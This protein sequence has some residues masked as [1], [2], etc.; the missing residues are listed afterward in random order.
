MLRKELVQVLR[1]DE[2]Q[3]GVS[4]ELQPLVGAQGEVRVADAAV[5]EGPGQQPYVVEL[6]ADR[7][8]ELGQF[9]QQLELRYPLAVAGRLLGLQG[10]RR[11]IH[12]DLEKI[13]SVFEKSFAEHTIDDL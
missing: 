5:R 6:D 4:E 13:G 3:N 1:R 9:L 7:L 10:M 11:Q 2:L 8:L 12:P